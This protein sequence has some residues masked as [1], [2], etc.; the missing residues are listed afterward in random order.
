LVD[1]K[2]ASIFAAPKTGKTFSTTSEN[3]AK[4]SKKDLEM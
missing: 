3:G 2:T 1:Q 4:K